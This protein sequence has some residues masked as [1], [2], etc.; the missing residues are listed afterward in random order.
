[1]EWS[2]TICILRTDVRTRL[3]ENRSDIL[4]VMLG[5]KVQWGPAP[6]R[7]F[8]GGGICAKFD[9]FFR[10][11][12]LPIESSNVD[13]KIFPAISRQVGQRDVP[14]VNVCSEKLARFRLFT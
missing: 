6:M 14:Q 8:F 1:M 12:C 13:R 3:D 11:S 7:A 4:L 9:D 5:R 2:P 10:N